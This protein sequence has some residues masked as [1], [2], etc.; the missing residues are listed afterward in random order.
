MW[1]IEIHLKVYKNGLMMLKIK[2]EK[3]SSLHFLRTRSTYKKEMSQ[4]LKVLKCPLKTTYYLKKS[5][6]KQEITFNNFSNKSLPYYQ[7]SMNQLLEVGS[8]LPSIISN[9]KMKNKTKQSSWRNQLSHRL[10][11]S[12]KKS[13]AVDDNFEWILCVSLLDWIN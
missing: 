6:L 12:K 9:S 2:E 8:I 13:H 3:E 7:K 10:E 4:N 1:P 11:E 5:V